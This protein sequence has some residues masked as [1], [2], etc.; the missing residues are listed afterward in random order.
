MHYYKAIVQYQGTRYAGFQWQNGLKTIQNEINI[1]L[2][3]TFV[4]KFSTMASSRTDSG[5]HAFH[6]V[7]KITSNT[8]IH[9]LTILQKLNRELPND[10]QF[11]HLEECAGSFKPASDTEK[12]EYRYFFTNKA[13]IPKEDGQLIA[14]IAKPLNLEAMKFCAKA[15]LGQHDFCNFYS[16]GSNVRTTVREVLICELTEV[17]PQ[18][19]FKNHPFFKISQNINQCYQLQI[20]ANGFLK[21]MIRHIVSGLWMVGSG[22]MTT[23]DFLLLIDGPKSKKQ[24]W[25]VAPANGLFLY[26]ITY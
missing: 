2:S 9:T 11:L 26:H 12:K 25:K 8:S 13:T 6:Q 3:N 7:V 18:N 22:K 17:N 21:Q 14:N 4:G 1:A 19:V 5:V 24:L 16:S 15:L 20:E 23:E 10:I